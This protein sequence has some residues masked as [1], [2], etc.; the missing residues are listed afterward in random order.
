MKN[1]PQLKGPNPSP[2]ATRLKDATKIRDSE[3]AE[4]KGNKERERVVC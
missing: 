3:N 4:R 1:T 2:S